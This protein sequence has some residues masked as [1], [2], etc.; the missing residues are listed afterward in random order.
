MDIYNHNMLLTV[1]Q[2]AT[3][4]DCSPRWVQMLTKSGKLPKSEPGKYPLLATV[5]AYLSHLHSRL[6]PSH[7]KQRLLKHK[8][9][10][11]E[12]Q[13][14]ELRGELVRAGDVRREIF[15]A[16]RQI[17]NTFQIMP[18]RIHRELA[19]MRD[20]FEVQNFLE[21]EVSATLNEIEKKL[22]ATVD[23]KNF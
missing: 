21:K 11:A 1:D 9:N 12:L 10:L 7:E 5:Q 8:A 4:F 16:S 2:V 18:S 14:L 6:D 15:T 23:G 20:R 22:S 17:R 13:E 3:L 19:I